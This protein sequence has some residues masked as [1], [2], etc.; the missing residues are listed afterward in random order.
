MIENERIQELKS[1]KDTLRQHYEKYEGMKNQAVM[2]K[3]SKQIADIE[4]AICIEELKELD[5]QVEPVLE[6]TKKTMKELQEKIYTHKD[7]CA[8]GELKRKYL[9]YWPYVAAGGILVG[10]LF[11]IYKCKSRQRYIAY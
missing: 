10:A 4:E 5:R 7:S 9:P 11:A 1:L 8:W 6:G 2:E 3:I